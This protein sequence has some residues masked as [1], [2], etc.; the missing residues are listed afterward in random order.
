MFLSLPLIFINRGPISESIAD[1]LLSGQY[2]LFCGTFFLL[3]YLNTNVLIPWLFLRKK[4]NL[5][6]IA[7][8]ILFGFTYSI[9][10]FD[11]LM[12]A[13]FPQPDEQWQHE[14]PPP[15]FPKGRTP[16]GPRR[17][18]NRVDIASIFLFLMVIALGLAIQIARQWR[19]SEQRAA[20]AEADKANAELSSLKAQINPHFMFNTLNN[21]YTL[22][23]TNSPHTA[24]SIMKLSALCVML[25]KM[26][27]RTM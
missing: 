12:L 6:F 18:E 27:R 7:V 2:W 17:L 3:F 14:P 9:K 20:L 10:P 23:I 4:H 1:M 13:S 26:L 25:P 19:L 22:A 11:N 8:V 5:Y 15:G 21:I 24:D 16:M